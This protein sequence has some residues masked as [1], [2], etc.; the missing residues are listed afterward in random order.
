MRAGELFVNLGIKGADKAVSAL[1]SVKAGVGQVAEAGLATKAVIAGLIYEF[2]QLT[3]SSNAYGMSLTQF[4][5]ITGQSAEKL[6]RWQ[7]LMRQSGISAEETTSN[8]EGLQKAMTQIIMNNGN[9]RGMTAVREKLGNDFDP[10]RIREMFYMLDRLREYARRTKD[11]PG[12]SNDILG[13]FNLTPGFIGAVRTSEVDLDKISPSKLYSA[14][15]QQALTQMSVGWANLGDQIEKSV[16][17]LNVQFGPDLLHDLTIFT[18][19]VLALVKAMADL[20]KQMN[21]LQGITNVFKA[22]T[23]VTA[24]STEVL[25]STK[26]PK[27]L[28]ILARIMEKS[29]MLED[30]PGAGGMYSSNPGGDISI[31]NNVHT[32][33]TVADD[34]DSAKKVAEQVSKTTSKLINDTMRQMGPVAQ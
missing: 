23:V 5:N 3:A 28:S 20:V 8:V 19:Q 22:A 11:V 17:R 30:I 6:Q 21:A 7:Y 33:V 12:E 16:G 14:K 1:V 29:G 15:E 24:A 9:P 10:T 26:E 2:E 13:S 25:N 31:V 32:S 18:T 4:N 27:N 34:I